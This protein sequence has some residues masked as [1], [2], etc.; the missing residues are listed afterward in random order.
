MTTD[1]TPWI[2][3]TAK[4][5]HREALEHKRKFVS[6]EPNPRRA[7]RAMLHWHKINRLSRTSRRACRAR[8]AIFRQEFPRLTADRGRPFPK[9]CRY[10]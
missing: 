4:Q 5:R 3:M 9:H 10:T 2:L 8:W 7:M 1:Q 6:A